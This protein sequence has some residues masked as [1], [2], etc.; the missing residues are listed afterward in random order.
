MLSVVTLVAVIL[1]SF[2]LTASPDAGPESEKAP[3]CLHGTSFSVYVLS[4]GRGV[5]DAAW[6][7][8]EQLR[9]MLT[10]RKADGVSVRVHEE[11]IGLE[12]ER[13]LCAEFRSETDAREAWRVA[14]DI[15]SGVELVN[16]KAEPCTP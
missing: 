7:V 13:R 15:A 4:R 12:G 10:S 14:K 5:P 6:T 9:D 16:L 1:L 2:P 8:L 3:G 11:R